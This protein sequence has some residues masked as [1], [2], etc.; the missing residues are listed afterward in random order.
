MDIDKI[1]DDLKLKRIPY[2]LATVVKVEGSAPRSA[3]AK[4]IVTADE[5]FGTI[6]GGGVEHEAI[7]DARKTLRTKCP[8]CALYDLTEEGIQPCGGTMEIFL[9]PVLPQKKVVVFGAGHIA[10]KLIPMLS[11]LNFE[12]TLVDEREGRLSLPAFLLADELS[13]ELPDEYLARC[14]F[15]EELNIIVLTHKH[16]HDE[17]IVE[18]CLDK[19]YRYLGL[20]SSRKKWSIFCGHYT[21]KSFT[22]EQMAKVSTPIG[23]DIGANTPFEIAVAIAAELIQRSEKPEDFSRGIGRFTK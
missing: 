17:S 2:C 19:S 15:D 7:E 18:F 4:M 10:E 20:I 14:K 11:E 13:E 6:G 3:G 22:D 16:I 8:K 12:I 21:E 23:L 9:E 1:S 5:S